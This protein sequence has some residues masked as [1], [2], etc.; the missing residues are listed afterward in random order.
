MKKVMSIVLA[1]VLLASMMVL[2]VVPV[3]AATPKED[4]I[5]AIKASVSAEY[6]E[7]YLCLK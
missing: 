2:T 4:I 5:A 6:F 1:C 3:S 7:K